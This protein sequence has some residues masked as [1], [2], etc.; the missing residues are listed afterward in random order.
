MNRI[1]NQEQRTKSK[2]PRVKNKEQGIR[3]LLLLVFAV[4]I[5]NVKAQTATDSLSLSQIISQIVQNHPSIKEA[6]EALNVADAKIGLAKASYLPYADV[7]GNY[8]RIYPVPEISFNGLKFQMAPANNYNAGVNLNQTVYDFGKTSKDVLSEQKG[9]EITQLT[10]EQVKQRMA[11]LATN[12]FYNLVYLQ[13][14]LQIK[15]EELKNLN[16][17]LSFVQ[18]KQQTGSGTQ[19][20]ILTIH[21]RISNVESQK[22]DLETSHKIQLS[23]LNSLLGQQG[24]VEVNVKKELAVKLPEI[25]VDSLVA[26]ALIHRDEIQ[27]SREKENLAQLKYNLT[28]SQ[29]NPV[30]NIF[31][32]GGVKDGYFPN[33]EDPKLNGAAGFGF[34][35]PIFD[36]RRLKNSSNIAKS[37]I[38]NSGYETEIAKRNVSN[39]VIEAETSSLAS[40]KKIKQYEM[41]LSQAKHALSLAEINYKAGVITNLDMLDATTI[42]SES[43]LMFLKSQIDYVACVYRLKAAIGDRLY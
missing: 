27:I 10:V 40:I 36:G 2:E 35:M 13:D 5:L 21:V 22:T 3:I 41:Q 14:A 24:N 7:S 33:L 11:I 28:K 15:D 17:H 9:K 12:T 4:F 6:E 23:V 43:Q 16:D 42:V 30:I 25:E 8:T 39:E 32:S 31:A 38:Q 18:K 19:Y 26:Y 29:N 34:K 37:N 1:K 20:E